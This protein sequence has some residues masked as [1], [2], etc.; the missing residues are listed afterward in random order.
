MGELVTIP[1]FYGG[2]FRQGG[3]TVAMSEDAPDLSEMTKD[4]L[5]AEAARR[6]VEVKAGATKADLLSALQPAT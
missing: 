1:G 5:L 6:G 4:Q 3:Q 2:R